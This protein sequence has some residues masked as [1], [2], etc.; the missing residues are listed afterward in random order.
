MQEEIASKQLPHIQVAQLFQDI[1]PWS[2][3]PQ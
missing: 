1:L 2:L 3:L